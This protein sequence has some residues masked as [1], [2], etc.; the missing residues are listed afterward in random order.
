MESAYMFGETTDIW[1][2][3]DIS[4]EALKFLSERSKYFGKS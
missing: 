2:K 1:R 4:E 3:A